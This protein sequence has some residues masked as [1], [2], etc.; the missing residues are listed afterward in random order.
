M[1]NL[2]TI[3][4][5]GDIQSAV[6]AV[7]DWSSEQCMQLNADKCKEM[8]IDF[9]NNKHVFSPVVVDEKEL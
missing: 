7:E 4:V 3:D 6:S 1:L 9:K 5:Q 8:F 2:C